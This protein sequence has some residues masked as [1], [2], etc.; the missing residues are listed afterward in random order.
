[1]TVCALTYLWS[2]LGRV[3]PSAA[4][5]ALTVSALDV[6]LPT[7]AY[8]CGSCRGPA[9]PG[10]SLT[11]PWQRVGVQLALTGRWSHGSFLERGRYVSTPDGVDAGKDLGVAIGVRIAPRL[12]LQ[13]AVGIGSTHLALA[14]FAR[15]TVG[16]ADSLVRV[17]YDV[18]QEP[19]VRLP[20]RVSKPSV[21]ATLS[22]RLPTGG[23]GD[24]P[25]NAAPSGLSSVGSF[26]T[27]QSLGTVEVALAVDV[28]KTFTDRLQLA[29][30]V[31]GA[32]RASDTA[33]GRA[34]ALGPRLLIRPVLLWFAAD[35]VTV[36]V[37]ADFG[38]EAAVRYDGSS[39]SGSSAYQWSTGTSMT[40]KH[41]NG[42]RTGLAFA[43]TP[44]VSGLG[45]NV[46]ASAQWTSFVGYAQ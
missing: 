5:V 20:N 31:E 25:A 15:R 41:D 33:F 28:R 7:T 24:A 34:R 13:A 37:F 11:A 17:R 1:V 27:N 45:E 21:G 2:N 36:A 8:A 10:A 44:P 3:A 43:F 16:L 22:V 23:R 18:L 46:A 38:V 40:F 9:G 29:G 4:Y 39:A 26:A 42:L 35:T 19:G 14:G 6:S 30:I 32:I 12:E